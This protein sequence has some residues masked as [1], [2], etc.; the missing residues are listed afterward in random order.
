MLPILLAQNTASNNALGGLGVTGE[1]AGFG[2]AAPSL[3]VIAAG[4]INAILALSGLALILLFV[5]GGIL[6]LTAGGE[7]DKV[8][9]AKSLMINAVIGVI[10]IVSSYALSTFVFSQLQTVVGEGAPAEAPVTPPTNP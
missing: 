1:T 6:Y 2:Q 8:K 5:Y 3:A 7:T 9:K 4:L 10:I